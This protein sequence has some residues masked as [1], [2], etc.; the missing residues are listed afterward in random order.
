M[1]V[2]VTIR[3]V[4]RLDEQTIVELAIDVVKPKNAQQYTASFDGR[5][6]TQAA[7]QLAAVLG[8]AVQAAGGTWQSISLQAAD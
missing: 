5:Y 6:A 1:K 2:A 3:Q 4:G 7:T 8:C